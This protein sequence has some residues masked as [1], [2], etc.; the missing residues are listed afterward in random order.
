MVMKLWKYLTTPTKQDAPGEIHSF[1]K[2]TLEASVTRACANCGAPGVDEKKK[3][4][5]EFCPNCGTKR[6]PLEPLGV[7][8]TKYI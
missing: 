3:D 4:V 8:W 6:P 7:I 2:Q 5:G 1:M